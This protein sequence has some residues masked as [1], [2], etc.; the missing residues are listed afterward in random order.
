[1]LRTIILDAY[2]EGEKDEIVK[3]FDPLRDNYGW[4]SAGIYC[5]W[6]YYTHET[7]YIGLAVDLTERF[8][9]HNGYYSAIDAKT[10]KKREIDTY[11]QTKD[12]IGFSIIVQSP[13]S[14][15]V[16]TRLKAEYKDFFSAWSPVEN[17][18]GEDGKQSI[19]HQEGVL[20]EAFRKVNGKLP[21]WNKMNGSVIGQKSSKLIN[22]ESI[23]V[24]SNRRTHPLM[25]RSSIRELAKDPSLE[26]YENFLHA[27]R[28]LYPIAGYENAINLLRKNSIIDSYG[29]MEKS[30]YLSKKLEI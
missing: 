1:M 23:K 19:K 26:R 15:P 28:I 22:F 21:K 6:D 25:S 17:Y 20:L 12:K 4:A 2:R 27:V 11:F 29:E 10:C 14:Q 13:L 30:G 3:A 5:Y 9:Q 24:L 16:T 18:V 8:K 7:Y